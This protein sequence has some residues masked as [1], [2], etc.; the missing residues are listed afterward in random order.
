M[1][2]GGTRPSKPVTPPPDGECTGGACDAGSRAGAPSRRGPQGNPRLNAASRLA[3]CEAPNF[4]AQTATL[5]RLYNESTMNSR[6]RA[7]PN[8]TSYVRETEDLETFVSLIHYGA[9]AIRWLI[10]ICKVVFWFWA[11]LLILLLV[12]RPL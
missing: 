8:T 3:H 12:L 1:L 7:S 9:V 5:Q 2:H 10:G 11:V 4:T 6:L